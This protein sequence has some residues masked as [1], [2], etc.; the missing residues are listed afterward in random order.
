MA[1]VTELSERERLFQAKSVEEKRL[2]AS[3]IRRLILENHNTIPKT[4]NNGLNNNSIPL[5]LGFIIAWQ[6][7][8]PPPKNVSLSLSP[9]L[10]F[11]KAQETFLE[12]DSVCECSEQI[13]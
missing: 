8:P 1:G 10:S 5:T 12:M 7:K 2:W 13:Y 9:S 6:P 4:V 3:H 11:F